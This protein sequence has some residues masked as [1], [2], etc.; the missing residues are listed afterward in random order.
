MAAACGSPARTGC[1]PRSHSSQA[2]GSAAAEPQ[3][4]DFQVV[5]LV[6]VHKAI[7]EHGQALAA[8]PEAHRLLKASSHFGKVVLRVREDER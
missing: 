4:P 7:D 1:P 5:G 3:V 8:A 6:R 2:S